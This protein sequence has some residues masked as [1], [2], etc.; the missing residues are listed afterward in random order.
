MTG[1][2]AGNV[3]RSSVRKSLVC[4]VKRYEEDNK[5]TTVGFCLLP[6]EW[7]EVESKQRKSS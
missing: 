7:I 2:E 1:D 3:A 5:V 4:L 6:G